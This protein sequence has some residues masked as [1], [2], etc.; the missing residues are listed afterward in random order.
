MVLCLAEHDQGRDRLPAW[1]MIQN[2]SLVLLYIP[3][4]LLA[5]QLGRA[6]L[7]MRGDMGRCDAQDRA[8][9][10]PPPCFVGRCGASGGWPWPL[11]VPFCHGA[12]VTKSKLQIL[13]FQSKDFSLF[14]C[15]FCVSCLLQCDKSQIQHTASALFFYYLGILE[16]KLTKWV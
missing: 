6:G 3:L 7:R 2:S 15:P 11:R 5:Y 13:I 9:P 4:A 8:P 14:T 10:P 1:K 12:S 16:G